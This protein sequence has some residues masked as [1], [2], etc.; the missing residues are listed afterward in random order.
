MGVAAVGE[1][2]M[3]E[4]TDSGSHSR[5]DGV[6]TGLE[7][8]IQKRLDSL[9]AGNTRRATETALEK[10]VGFLRRERDVHSLDD[11]DVQDCRRFAQYLRRQVHEGELAASTANQYYARVRASCTWWVEDEQLATNPA[12]ATRATKE[13]PEDTAEP[14]RQS[15]SAEQRAQLLRHT[16][17]A[18]DAILEGQDTDDPDVDGDDRLLAYRDRALAYLLAWAGVRGGEV[19]RDPTDEK[20]NGVTWAALSTDGVL[21]VLGKTRDPEYAP[22]RESVRD[23]LQLWKRVLDPPHD[24]WPIFPTVDKRTL[25][26]YLSE[27]YDH[28]PAFDSNASVRERL[29]HYAEEGFTPP[30]ISTNAGRGV[31]QRLTETAG[32]DVDA[33]YLQ[34]H[35]GRRGLGNEVYED[36]PVMA[37]DLLRHK[38]IETTN[39]A[40]REQEQAKRAK[41][42]DERYE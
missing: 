26:Q 12:K 38:S 13:L 8:A 2:R 6:E 3:V 36:D 5:G 21:R 14:D 29:D 31:M 18:V 30:A 19:L 28:E 4:S 27:E 37:Q 23:R 42:L 20:R 24:D 15:W 41:E 17:Q 33:G 40:Y 25:K 16:D 22:L 10:F 34:P 9:E 11:L 32:I 35:G 39:E 7:T 1:A